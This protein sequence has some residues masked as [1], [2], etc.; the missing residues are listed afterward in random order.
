MSGISLWAVHVSACAQAFSALISVY[1][2]FW[3]AETPLGRLWATAGLL[4]S[5]AVIYGLWPLMWSV[6][7]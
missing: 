4:L 5:G 2:L 7:P 6:T 1:C 3:D